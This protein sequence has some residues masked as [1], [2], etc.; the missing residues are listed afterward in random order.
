VEGLFLVGVQNWSQLEAVR[1]VTKLPLLLGSTP[2]EMKDQERLSQLNV[3][4]A[5]EGHSSY[6]A[7]ILATYDELKRLRETVA[8]VKDDAP[9]RDTLMKSLTQDADYKN[10]INAYINP[11]K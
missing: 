9:Q 8:K 5:L 3:K 6:T 1:A 7:A 2:K 4:V 11:T 10:W